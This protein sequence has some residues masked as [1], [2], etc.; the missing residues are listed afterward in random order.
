MGNDITAGPFVKLSCGITKSSVWFESPATRVVWI[1][2]LTEADQYGFVRA[3]YPGMLHIA[4]VPKDDFDKA[5]EILE[6]PDQ[7][8]RTPN[9]EGRRIERVDGGW[10]ILNYEKYRQYSYSGTKEAERKRKQRERKIN[11]LNDKSGTKV[12]QV[13]KGMGH[14]ASASISASSSV[15][16]QEKEEIVKRGREYSEE[17][18]KQIA[19]VVEILNTECDTSFRSTSA[20]TR[21][22]INA[23]IEEGYHRADFEAVVRF[24]RE[25]WG[26]DPKMSEYLRPITLFGT[27]FESYLQAAKR[28]GY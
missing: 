19:S 3:S 7:M 16:D 17:R 2:L 5:L 28:E 1:A 18:L 8:S 26:G 25:E 4:N 12:G 22:H 23:R 27:K 9:Y 21:K 15:S 13:T 24:K 14:S 11:G 6:S 20:A 10:R